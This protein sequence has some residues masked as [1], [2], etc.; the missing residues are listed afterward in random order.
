LESLGDKHELHNLYRESLEPSISKIA[1]KRVTRILDAK[2]DKANLY[3]KLSK[4]AANT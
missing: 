1:T 2:Y 3:Q 4:T